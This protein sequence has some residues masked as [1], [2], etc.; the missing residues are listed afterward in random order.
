MIEAGDDLNGTTRP[1]AVY[2]DLFCPKNIPNLS[3]GSS[4]IS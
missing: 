1:S 2:E 3:N 4:T